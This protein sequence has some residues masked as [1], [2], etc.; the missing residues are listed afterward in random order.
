MTTNK[1]MTKEQVWELIN[2]HNKSIDDYINNVLPGELEQLGYKVTNGKVCGLS[3]WF[4]AQY[5]IKEQHFDGKAVKI[6]N[7]VRA[8]GFDVKMDMQAHKLVWYGGMINA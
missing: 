8:Q 1:D 5:L 6:L 2:A 3:S 7:S 4:D